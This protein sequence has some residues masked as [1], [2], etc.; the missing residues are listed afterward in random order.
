VSLIIDIERESKDDNI[1]VD[2]SVCESITED[3]DLNA[4]ADQA[5]KEAGVIARARYIYMRKLKTTSA[6]GRNKWNKD[7]QG[8][9]SLYPT[10]RYA[11]FYHAL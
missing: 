2:D 9:V 10:R 8:L 4:A 6:T 3:E 5:T 1:G 11:S 7:S